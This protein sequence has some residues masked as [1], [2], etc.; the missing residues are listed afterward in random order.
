MELLEWYREIRVSCCNQRYRDEEKECSVCALERVLRSCN[1]VLS[2]P[3]SFHVSLWSCERRDADLDSLIKCNIFRLSLQ[4]VSWDS[5]TGNLNEIAFLNDHVFGTETVSKLTQHVLWSED[6]A[7]YRATELKSVDKFC[8]SKMGLHHVT[9]H[10]I[11]CSSIP[12]I[13]LRNPPTFNVTSYLQ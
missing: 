9:Y 2:L 3:I 4:R 8:L 7:I 13:S 6:E 1:T 12:W 10:V 5:I 11:I